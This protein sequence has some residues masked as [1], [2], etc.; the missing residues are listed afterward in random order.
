[1]PLEEK[2][3]SIRNEKKKM[4]KLTDDFFQRLPA[5]LIT[6]I[7]KYLTVEN[8]KNMMCVNKLLQEYAIQIRVNRFLKISSEPYYSDIGQ[9]YLHSDQMHRYIHLA[10]KL[11]GEEVTQKLKEVPEIFHT[12]ADSNRMFQTTHDWSQGNLSI[13]TI[14]DKGNKQKRRNKDNTKSKCY[15]CKQKGHPMRDCIFEPEFRNHEEYCKN[16]SIHVWKSWERLKVY[17]Q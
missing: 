16:N 15:I 17:H 12:T 14:F 9:D 7:Y 10:L 2:N 8:L 5:E 11:T 4:I 1:M 3:D 13:E 6:K